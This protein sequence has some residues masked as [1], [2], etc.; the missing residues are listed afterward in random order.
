MPYTPTQDGTQA[1]AIPASP[2]TINSVTY[3]AEDI[4]ITNPAKVIEINDSN[5][6]P[7]GQTIIPKNS[8][9]TMK[10]QLATINTVVPGRGQTFTLVGATFY[11]TDVGTAYQ[12]GEYVKVNVS[13]VC[14]IN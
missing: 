12:Q 11:V 3:I 4:N 1:F 5:A 2:V 8:T 10:L 13:G 7:T 14:K 6:I 9:L